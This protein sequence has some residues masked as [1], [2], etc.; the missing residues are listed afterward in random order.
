MNRRARAR[1]ASTAARAGGKDHRLAA[2]GLLESVVEGMQKVAL[3]H[4]HA[5]LLEAPSLLL[6]TN[7]RDR[8]VAA[9]GLQFLHDAK[10]RV[11]VR[12]DDQCSHGVIL[13][14]RA[15]KP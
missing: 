7:H 4:G 8:L 2:V 15:Y 1:W 10:A 6:L 14:G 12:S 3:H 5:Q 13:S 11:S 9:G